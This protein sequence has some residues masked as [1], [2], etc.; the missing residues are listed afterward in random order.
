MESCLVEVVIHF[1]HLFALNFEHR[2]EIV[3]TAKLKEKLNS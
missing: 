3:K 2:E 1:S